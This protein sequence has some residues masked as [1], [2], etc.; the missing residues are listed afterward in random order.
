MKYVTLCAVVFISTSTMAGVVLPNLMKS[1]SIPNESPIAVGF[2]DRKAATANV[3]YGTS[4]TTTNGIKEYEDK[5][6][7]LNA[8]AF[9]NHNNLVSAEVEIGYLRSKTDNKRNNK[10][11]TNRNHDFAASVGVTP[12]EMISAGISFSRETQNDYAENTTKTIDTDQTITPAIGVKITPEIAIG[13]GVDFIKSKTTV[14]SPT[15]TSMDVV[16]PTLTSERFFLGAAYGV[17]QKAA[18]NGFGTELVYSHQGKE[19]VVGNGITVSSGT[20]DGF[21]N[22]T[23]YLTDSSDVFFTLAYV[24]G[25]D[26][27]EKV[28]TETYGMGLRFEQFVHTNFY[29]APLL[30]YANSRGQSLN[31]TAN[32]KTT[33]LGFGLA[34][35][36]RTSQFDLELGYSRG[37]IDSKYSTSNHTTETRGGETALRGTYYF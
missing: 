33:T 6:T 15:P 1:K 16:Y 26:Y 20:T 30:S 28:K 18:A 11:S 37:N 21:I 36:Y 5:N 10:S 24:T 7:T 32:N 23:H 2:S 19:K 27:D 25:K 22:T 34:A 17:N 31:T 9:Y 3:A 4:N 35:G 8:N 29:L 12:I 13:A 14:K